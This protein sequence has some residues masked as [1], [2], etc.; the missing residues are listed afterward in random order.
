MCNGKQANL[1][2]KPVC[3]KNYQTD[4]SMTGADGMPCIG[5]WLW[6]GYFSLFYDDLVGMFA[7]VPD[8][9]ADITVW[10]FYAVVVCCHLKFMVIF[11]LGSTAG[12]SVLIIWQW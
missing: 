7:D 8:V 10:E 6:G 11:W 2:A 12:V 3:W 9:S 1:P 4:A 5:A